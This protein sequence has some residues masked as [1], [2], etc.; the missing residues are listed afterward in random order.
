MTQAQTL[1][2]ALWS[3]QAYAA[4]YLLQGGLKLAGVIYDPAAHRAF[5]G[6]PPQGTQMRYYGDVLGASAAALAV[7][8]LSRFLPAKRP[9]DLWILTGTALALIAFDVTFFFSR[10]LAAP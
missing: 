3:I 4:F 7:F 8:A 2:G 5:F 1:R 9:P 6:G 10:V